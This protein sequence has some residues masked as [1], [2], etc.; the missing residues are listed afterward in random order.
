MSNRLLEKSEID[1]IV[2]FAMFCGA[3]KVTSLDFEASSK[4]FPFLTYQELSPDEL[5]SWLLGPNVWCYESIN[6]KGS[7]D[8]IIRDFGL[9]PYKFD[10]DLSVT[11]AFAFLKLLTQYYY[12]CSLWSGWY[13]SD[14]REFTNG[15]MYRIIQEIII[16][17]ENV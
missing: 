6:G 7:A 9:V 8:G 5:G 2:T 11:D 4:L 13:L 15:L 12:H 10:E 16:Q 1:Q 14:Q 3:N 17:D